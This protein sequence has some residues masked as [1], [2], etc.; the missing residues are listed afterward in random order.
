MIAPLSWFLEDYGNSFPILDIP[1]EVYGR[2]Q[3]FRPVG[4][5]DNSPAI[6]RWEGGGMSPLS[7]PS[8]RSKRGGPF[9]S[10]LRD[11]WTKDA[12]DTLVQQ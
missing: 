10:S 3:G 8:G 4:S 5:V 12:D 1:P 11:L 6:Y 7:V 9:R 2:K